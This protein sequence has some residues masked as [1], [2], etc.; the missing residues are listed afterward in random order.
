SIEIQF[1]G[2]I[3]DAAAGL[4]LRYRVHP[5]GSLTVDLHYR[6]RKT[7]PMLMRVGTAW[8]LP[9]DF[10]NVR[11][12]G[13]GPDPSYTDRNWQPVGIYQKTILENWVDY[14]KPQ[15][16]GNKV[17]VRWIE[18]TDAQGTGLR[19]TS[20]QGLS[21]NALPFSACEMSGH[22]YSWQLP[23]PTAVHLNIDHAQMGVGGDNSWGDIALPEYQLREKT[24]RYQYTV[25][26]IE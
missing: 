14:S 22:A 16:N 26:P 18:I 3:L 9:L 6:A 10:Q 5:S 2:S 15:E 7:L 24:Y 12:Y 11:W 25:T 17:E 13:P 20:K 19:F 1:K 8:Q 23:E 4:D 21:A